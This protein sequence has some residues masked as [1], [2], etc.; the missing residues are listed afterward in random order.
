MLKKS[1][2]LLKHL[3]PPQREAVSILEGPLLVLAGAG[4]G[5]TR[6]IT[7]RIA[8]MIRNGIPPKHIAGMTFTNKAAHE[9]RERLA[10]LIPDKDAKQV[11]L[12]TFHAFCAKLLRHEIEHLGFARNFTIADES[13]QTGILKQAI[14]EAGISGNGIDASIYLSL[15][16]RAKCNLRSPEDFTRLGV[17]SGEAWG[18]ETEVE[19]AVSYVYEHYQKI[20]KNQNMLDFDD[21]LVFVVRL[22]K[23]HP[24]ILKKCREK[25]KYLLVDE[26]QDTNYVQFR[27]LK[28]LAGKSMNICVVGDDDQSIYGWRGAEVKNILEFPKHFPG[29]KKV[30][31]EQNYRSANTILQAANSLISHNTCRHDKHLWSECGQGENLQ[32][33][34]AE[35][36]GEEARYI[37]NA[38]HE[39]IGNAPG[40]KYREFAVLYRS[41]Y[42]SR[43]IEDAMRDSHLPYKLVGARSFYDRREI[44]DAVAYLKLIV[45]LKDDQSLLR[46]LGVPPRGIGD[47]AIELLRKLQSSTSLSF[48]ELLQNKDFFDEISAKAAGGASELSNCLEKWRKQFSEPGNLYM[49]ARNFLKETG[50]FDGLLKIYKQKDEAERRRE[51][52]DELI[53]SIAGFELRYGE[54]SSLSDFLE[55]YSL[56]DDNDKIKDKSEDGDSVTL[57]TVHA[58]KGLEFTHVFIAGMEHNIFPHERALR[59]RSSEEERRLFYVALTRAKS[60]IVITR[61]R[62]RMRY[63]KVS[64]Q[65]PSSFLFELPEEL[66]EKI[67]AE[68]AFQ[69]MDTDNLQKAFASFYKTFENES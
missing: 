14:A 4:T 55:N 12:G 45:N 54:T 51:N 21:L 60:K 44:R 23:D 30:K 31:L 9:M 66:V 7:F 17:A 3:N 1:E 52:V 63:G 57:M 11:S 5:K 22:W 34:T 24:A 67:D 35:N 59:D 27:L 43:Q 19:S 65:K 2:N 37:S 38:I 49:K 69:P 42:Q 61:A 15:I 28:L 39:I 10:G 41:N 32:I 26:Y 46:I 8:N 56:A 48:C 64:S 29:T 18:A 36:D 47:K 25:Y 13:D 6:V 53:N 16:S 50:L 62:Q 68:D 33:V 40:T 20:L 58:A